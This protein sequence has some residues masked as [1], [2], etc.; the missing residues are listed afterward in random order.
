[1]IADFRVTQGWDGEVLI[2]IQPDIAFQLAKALHQYNRYRKQAS[3]PVDLG[4]EELASALE[5][6][7]VRL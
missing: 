6:L 2:H 1:M 7:G 3:L 5:P 4:W